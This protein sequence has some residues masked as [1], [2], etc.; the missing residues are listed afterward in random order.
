MYTHEPVLECQNCG[1]VVRRLSEEEAQRVAAN[2][3]NFIVYCAGC[4]RGLE[5]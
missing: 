2:P 4:R 5:T 3:Y 1:E